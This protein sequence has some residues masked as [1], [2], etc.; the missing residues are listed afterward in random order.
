MNTMQGIVPHFYDLLQILYSMDPLQ[1]PTTF[2]YRTIK[3]QLDD[4]LRFP[5]AA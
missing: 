3:P 5:V 2:P 1:L 4:T